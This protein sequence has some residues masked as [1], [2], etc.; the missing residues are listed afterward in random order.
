MG[1]LAPPSEDGDRHTIVALTG[2]ERPGLEQM[3]R[4]IQERVL[5]SGPA[6]EGEARAEVARPNGAAGPMRGLAQAHTRM[7]QVRIGGQG[8]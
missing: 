4:A 1:L 3:V 7:E 5:D 6:D 8:R 2:R